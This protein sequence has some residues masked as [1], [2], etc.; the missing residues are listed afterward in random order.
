[1]ADAILSVKVV[2]GASRSRV[3]GRYGEGVKVQVAAAPERGR[4]NQAV[5]EVL[6]EW[7]AIRPARI[8]I[9][10]GHTQSRKQVVIIGVSQQELAAH[11]ALL[12]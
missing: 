11:M 2:P 1:M 6:A 4:A 12:A 7:L 9:R 5:I 8:A 10:S 3:A